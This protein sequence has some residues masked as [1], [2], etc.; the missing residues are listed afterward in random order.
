MESDLGHSLCPSWQAVP[1]VVEQGLNGTR[2]YHNKPFL[3]AGGS[4]CMRLC[5][6]FR[7][8][9]AEGLASSQALSHPLFSGFKL[10][11]DLRLGV[12]S[13]PDIYLTIFESR[14]EITG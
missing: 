2:S 14:V 11:P 1:P 3:K 4:V 8:Q 13:L 6:H 7:S 10:R 5:V 12:F 9:Q